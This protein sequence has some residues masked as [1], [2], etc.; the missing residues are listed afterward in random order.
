MSSEKQ[1]R[2]LVV[3]LGSISGAWIPVL[4]ARPDIKIVGLVDLMVESARKAAIKYGLDPSIATDSLETAL[5]LTKPELVC[6]CTIPDSRR[7]VVAAVLRAG[8]HVLTEKPMAATIKDARELL[9]MAKG[10]GVT[11]A[12]MQNRRYLKSIIQYRDTIHSGAIG[13]LTTINVDFY[14]GPHFGGFREIMQNVLLLDMAIHTF[15]QARFITGADPVAVYCHEWNPKGSWYAHGA[16]AIA[17]FEMTGG[18]VFTYRGSWCAVGKSTSWEGTWRA[19]GSSGTL[20]WEQAIVDGE[21]I[22]STD[23]A[24]EPVPLAAVP[25]MSEEGHSALITDFLCCLAKGK[26][27]QTCASDNIKSLAMVYG[28]VESSRTGKRVLIE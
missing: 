9:A 6:D 27:P 20:V 21:R 26:M 5:D 3:G 1:L 16:S 14:L 4:C 2:V 13:D 11:Y 8:C 25:E 18:I 28:A 15:D 24:V 10:A 22:C 12:V 17:I 7:D 19:V 23:N